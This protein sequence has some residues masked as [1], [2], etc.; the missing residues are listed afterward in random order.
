MTKLPSSREVISILERNGF[1]FI[2]QKGSHLKFNKGVFTV[3]V[4]AA[5]KEIPIGT[6]KSIVRQSGLSESEFRNY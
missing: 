1:V 3:I 5:R 6:Y 4:P 2:S